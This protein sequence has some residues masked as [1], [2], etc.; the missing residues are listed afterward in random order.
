MKKTLIV[1]GIISFIVI[2]IVFFSPVRYFYELFHNNQHAIA[3][4]EFKKAIKKFDSSDVT[5]KDDLLERLKIID[6]YINEGS[7]S[8]LISVDIDDITY[9]NMITLFNEPDETISSVSLQ[10]G[11]TVHQYKIDNTTLNFHSTGD[12]IDAFYLEDFYNNFY[13]SNELDDIFL[14]AINNHSNRTSDNTQYTDENFENTLDIKEASRHVYRMGWTIPSNKDLI[15]YD[16]GKAKYSPEEYVLLKFNKKYNTNHLRTIERRY[17]ESFTDLYDKDK[18]Q[19][20]EETF[21]HILKK[22]SI[23]E[24]QNNDYTVQDLEDL[25]GDFYTLRYHFDYEELTISW[26]VAQPRNMNEVRTVIN[27]SELPTIESLDDLSSFKI[28]Y[29]DTPAR[30]KYESILET[31]TYIAK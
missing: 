6:N 17:R 30:N 31:N 5:G 26:Y 2:I 24:L 12:I 13:D 11:N 14:T 1:L 27:L 8:I 28:T 10:E 20:N 16:D 7:E 18:L 22:F 4:R 25:L 3:N 29:V 19:E 9:D 15:Y 21:Q 23:E